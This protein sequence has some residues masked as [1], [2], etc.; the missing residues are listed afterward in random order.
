MGVS[1]VKRSVKQPVFPE[2]SADTIRQIRLIVRNDG[3]I[4]DVEQYLIS[5]GQPLTP[6]TI[7]SRCTNMGMV[8]SRRK[9]A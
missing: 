1:Q 3:R 7:H 9:G 8:F 5:I 2:W 6:S 4:R